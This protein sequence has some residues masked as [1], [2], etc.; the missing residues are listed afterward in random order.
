MKHLII[1]NFTTSVKFNKMR[2]IEIVVP[3]IYYATYKAAYCQRMARRMVCQASTPD[4]LRAAAAKVNTNE[5]PWAHWPRL[6]YLQPPEGSR[7]SCCERRN[8]LT[9]MTRQK[10]R[11]TNVEGLGWISFVIKQIGF[12]WDRSTSKPKYRKGRKY[13]I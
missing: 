9:P 4:Q 6:T 11:I 10:P 5:V 13:T 1:T 3:Y 2:T 12:P 7:R 8:S